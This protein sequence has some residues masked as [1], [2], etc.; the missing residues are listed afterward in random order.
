MHEPLHPRGKVFSRPLRVHCDLYCGVG[1]DDHLVGSETT[2]EYFKMIEK[3]AKLKIIEGGYHELH[4]E[5]DKFSDDY[6]AFLK[7]SI[8]N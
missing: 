4:N 6:L 1:T 2:I 5:I 8:M 7:D 3:N